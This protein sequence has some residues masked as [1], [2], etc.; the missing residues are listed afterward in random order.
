MCR[1]SLLSFSILAAFSGFAFADEAKLQPEIVVTATRVAQ[2]VDETLADVSIITRQDIEASA[3]RD[4][5]DLLRL[6]AGVDITR[7]GGPG[8]QTSVFLRGTNNNHVL[9]LIDGVRV[10]AL[11]TGA[12]TWETLPLATIE[13]I[14]IVR[15]PRA[16]YWG[17]DAIGGVIQ[18]FTRKLDG[19]RVALGYGSYGDANADIGIGHRSDSG[20]YSVQIG[21][22]DEDGFPS[23]NENG[24]GY[25]DKDHGLRNRHLS[26]RADQRWGDQTLQGILVRSQGTAEFAG[27]SSNFTQQMISVTLD[28]AVTP[29]WQHRLNV[30]HSSEDYATPAFFS[31]YKSRRSTLGWQNEISLSEQQ[32][33]V[34]GIDAIDERGDNRE[35]FGNTS[36]Y[37]ESRRNTGV[38]AG[39]QVNIRSFNSAVSVRNDDNSNF[40]NETTGSVAA[41]WRFNDSLRAYASYGEGFRGPTLN[42]QYSPGF[43][44]LYAGNPDLKPEESSSSE[45]GIELAPDSS[46]RFKASLYST[47]I[48]NLI[49]F[50]GTDFQAENIA[51]ARIKGA[52]LGYE[53]SL[54]VWQVSASYTWLR[55]RNEDTGS[56]L[57]RRPRQ[58][59]TATVERSFGE[60]LRIG[61]ELIDSGSRN[62]VGGIK[63][64]G[65]T[66]VNLRAG[67]TL[68]PQW[69]LR[70]RIENL[71]DRDYELARGY[72]TPGRSGFL[73]VIWTTR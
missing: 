14:E 65:Y 29:A 56:D 3:T 18:I 68:T 2:T 30:G 32:L 44:G 15:G 16:S 8:G 57:L 17:S 55:P 62:D 37:R 64:P 43:G 11:G 46:Q 69:A 5:S 25:E 51:R 13:R 6:E 20:G 1:Y 26:A 35:T 21:A 66:L 12:F 27:G 72:N 9:V 23:Q 54:G 42:E 22:R 33:L 52:E 63:L 4:I 24:F 34:L 31:A 59:F 28:G 40:G 48:H 61:A 47:R 71:T 39:W 60:S 49:S 70:A 67:W 53:K 50:T 36:V 7:T 10:S 73:E 45:I 19:A 38:Y 58:K 41:G